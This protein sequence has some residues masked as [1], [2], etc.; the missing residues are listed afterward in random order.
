MEA[1]ARAQ[2]PK[3]EGANWG[4]WKVKMELFL[5][6]LGV[7]YTVT[8]EMTETNRATFNSDCQ[9]ARAMLLLS[10]H[11]HIL[12][13]LMTKR[14]ARA[15]WEHLLAVY[16]ANTPSRLLALQRALAE[17]K[18]SSS[19]NICAYIGRGIELFAQLNTLN[20]TI[21]EHNVCLALLKGLDSEAYSMIV[22]ILTTQREPLSFLDIQETL[23]RRE[24]EI[25]NSPPPTTTTIFTAVSPHRHANVQCHRCKQMGHIRKNCP[26]NKVKPSITF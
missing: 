26:L 3:L 2:I 10:V 16:E 11:D 5:I 21:S 8:E 19:E 12:P 17:L 18:K 20:F 6:V 23:V 14:T 9:K 7:W 1:L 13:S 24:T 25:V 4:V 15:L 22:T